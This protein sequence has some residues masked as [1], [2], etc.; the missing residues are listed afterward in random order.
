MIACDA[1]VLALGGASW[2][3]LGSDGGWVGIMEDAG[4]GVAPLRPTNC[5]FT[6]AWSEI[7]QNRFQGEPLKR[8]VVRF[9]DHTSMGEAMVTI[10]RRSVWF[11]SMFSSSRNA[12]PTSW[13]GSRV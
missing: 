10:F 5:G 2:P 3:R 1:A 6:V 11:E 9:G 13:V 8:L 4:I 7:F 12:K